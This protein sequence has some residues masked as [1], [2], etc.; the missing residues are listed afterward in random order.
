MSIGIEALNR[1]SGRAGEREGKKIRR[2]EVK[3]LKAQRKLLTVEDP[4]GRE[5]SYRFA[6]KNCEPETVNPLHIAPTALRL[7][8]DAV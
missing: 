8:P 4:L 2:S 5:S 7:P 3:R 1:D 6:M